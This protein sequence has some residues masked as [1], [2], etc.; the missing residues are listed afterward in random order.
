MKFC[1]ITLN[2]WTS[3]HSTN[4]PEVEVVISEVLAT[5]HV[6]KH[7]ETLMERVEGAQVVPHETQ[8]AI[9]ATISAIFHKIVTKNNVMK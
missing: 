4:S 7:V 3:I 9:I 5:T 6:V 1:K 2:Q 8:S